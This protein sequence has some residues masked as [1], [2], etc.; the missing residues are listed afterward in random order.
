MLS[1]RKKRDLSLLSRGL[2]YRLKISF[3]L[4]FL[5]P[6]LIS[7]YLLSN[8]VFPRAGLP[9]ELFLSLSISMIIAIIGFFLIKE[10]FD[11]VLTIA[12]EARLIAAGDISRKVE[13]ERSDE[14]GDLG[15]ALNQLTQ[16]IRSNMDELKSY[17]RKTTQINMEI[18]KR[19]LALSSLLQ[20]SSLVSEGAEL[21]DI[22]DM[23]VDKAGLLAESE[24]AYL[25]LKD[26]E[27]DS[28]LIKFAVG[29]GGDNLLG[30]KINASDAVFGSLLTRGDI[31]VAD[32][33]HKKA[34]DSFS[35]RF[36]FRNTLAVA[37]P[38]R[39][40]ITAV[41]GIVNSKEDF[42]YEDDDAE[43]LDIF[44]RQ[45]S[46]AIENDFLLHKAEKLEIRDALTGLFNEN[47]INGRLD[48]E[49]K[50]AILCQRPCSFAVFDIDDFARFRRE[51]GAISAEISLKKVAGVI[52]DV[53][54]EIDRSGRTAD[55]EFSVIMPEKNKRQSKEI[56]DVIRGKVEEMFSAEPEPGRRLTISAG[57]SENPLDGITGRE[58]IERARSSVNLAK[59]QGK[60]KVV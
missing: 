15:E 27:S 35:Q 19:V 30:M 3:Y 12:L 58:L 60:N 33:D 36:R 59:A 46:I 2:K 24:A 55:N 23:A 5:L 17:G 54:S 47:Y 8:Y 56:A 28:F 43:L 31:F 7:V 6:F 40:E 9:G 22:L 34:A 20:I 29:H 52:H 21:K 41:L 26:K 49:I 51:F 32:A 44:G 14:V 13:I 25:F 1:G 18:Q 10:V 50:R 45:I 57:V 42:T 39:N 4:I 11:R 37:V 16:R 38:L 48:E 53:I